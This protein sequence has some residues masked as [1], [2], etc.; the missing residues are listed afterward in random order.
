M[1]EKAVAFQESGFEEPATGLAARVAHLEDSIQTLNELLQSMSARL[2]A[3]VHELRGEARGKADEVDL[4]AIRKDLDRITS[5][6]DGVEDEVGSGETLDVAKVPPAILEHAYQAVLDGI[7]A[8]LRKA[9]GDHDAERHVE[10]SLEELRLRTSG[11][12]LFHY[13]AQERR[14]EV[15]VRKALEKGLAS[16]RQIQ[17][18]FEELQRN[19]LEPIHAHAP[20]NFRALVKLKSH[21]FAVDRAL[22]LTRDVERT[23]AQ[24]RAL[25][26]RLDRL[27][28]HVAGALKDVQEFAADLRETLANVATRESIEA[29]QMRL[30]AIEGRLDGHS[31]K[32]A[33]VAT[34]LTE[35]SVLGALARGP[36]TLA[37]LRR[38]LD[39][40]DEDLRE[41]LARLQSRDLIASSTRGKATTYRR[42]ED[43]EHA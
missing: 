9:L 41:A 20:R 1:T 27:E 16:A 17:M 40:G 34:P 8:E 29:L 15:G 36:R 31:P 24:A 11:S 10:H 2:Q 12:E 30:A 4:A 5:R 42:K 21:E 25:Q 37:E 38:D 28:A 33:E 19:L 7:V 13:R 6:V 35:E 43:L 3:S 26:E 39:A 22:H 14:I 18:T 23:G 32:P